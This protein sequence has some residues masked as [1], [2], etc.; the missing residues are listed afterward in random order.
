VEVGED[1][2]REVRDDDSG[3]AGHRKDDEEERG[4]IVDDGATRGGPRP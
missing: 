4:R 1:D 2:A 3:D